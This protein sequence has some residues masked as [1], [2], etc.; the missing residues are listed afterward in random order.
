MHLLRC[1]F[2]SFVNLVSETDLT[3]IKTHSCGSLKCISN[4]SK[5]MFSVPKMDEILYTAFL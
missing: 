3:N 5:H 2:R 4:P 1:P